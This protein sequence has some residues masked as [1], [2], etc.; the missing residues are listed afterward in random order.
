MRWPGGKTGAIWIVAVAATVT[1]V[2]AAPGATAAGRIKPGALD[3][4]ENKCK[5]K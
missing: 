4:L 2:A 1:A 5:V 3:D